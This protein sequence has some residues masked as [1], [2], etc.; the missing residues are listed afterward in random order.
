MSWSP[1]WPSLLASIDE[2]CRVFLWDVAHTQPGPND[3]TSPPQVRACICAL[4][5]TAGGAREP[6]GAYRAGCNWLLRPGQAKHQATFGVAHLVTFRHMDDRTH[7][8][9]NT[10]NT[11]THASPPPSTPLLP[12]LRTIHSGHASVVCDLAWSTLR[13][14]AGAPPAPLIATVS[15]AVFHQAGECFRASA[16]A[17]CATRPACLPASPAAPGSRQGSY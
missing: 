13:L 12:Q 8:H 3:F 9:T 2:D 7:M 17:A 5:C 1:H 15:F 11:H 4:Q 6:K 16:W 14:A 10:H